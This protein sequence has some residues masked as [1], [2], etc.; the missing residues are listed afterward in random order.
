MPYL[1]EITGQEALVHQFLHL[2]NNQTAILASHLRE[3]PETEQEIVQWRHSLQNHQFCL[4]GMILSLRVHLKP[5]KGL[6]DS[7]M[8]L[9]GYASDFVKHDP[10][11]A[12]GL[13][14]MCK[15]AQSVRHLC[16]EVIATLSK[17][18]PEAPPE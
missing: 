8:C 7:P 6:H 9:S 14:E 3:K 18:F 17:Q 1:P 11:T 10:E 16:Q 12:A 13:G 5:P 2:F 15:K 4:A